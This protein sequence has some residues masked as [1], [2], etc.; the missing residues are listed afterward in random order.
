MSSTPGS[1]YAEPQYFYTNGKEVFGPFNRRTIIEMESSRSITRETLICEQGSEAWVKLSESSLREHLPKRPQP[2]PSAAGPAMPATSEE[3]SVQAKAK[4][5]SAVNMTKKAASDI[6]HLRMQLLLPVFE[7][8]TLAW[9]Q[10]KTALGM[11]VVGL[12]PLVLTY[13]IGGNPEASYYGIAFYFA[14]MWGLY[15]YGALAPQS[16]TVGTSLLC[17]FVTALMSIP[18]LLGLYYLPPFGYLL[19]LTDSESLA[20][21]FAGMLA[22]VAI[23]EEICKALVL[24]YLVRTATAKM[25]PNTIVFYGLMSGLGFGIYEGVKYQMGFNQHVADTYS[26]LHTLNVMRLTTLPFIHAI[27]TG[28]AG[29]FI[30]LSAVYPSRKHGL[31][32]V[33]ILIPALFH[34]IHNT[35][36]IYALLTDAISVLALL[37]YLTKS[38]EIETELAKD[39]PAG[40][41]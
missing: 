2:P 39:R 17:F 33:A 12:T 16:V 40:A 20:A 24:F 38:N 3:A 27:W 37:V 22:A 34:A 41:E 7:L 11:I 26:E 30:G 14:A 4:I 9:L 29:Y 10:N 6:S 28:I 21:Q 18:I 5:Q 36:G 32:A 23:P 8:R 35:F 25:H 1:I 15:F 13:V 19:E 31:I